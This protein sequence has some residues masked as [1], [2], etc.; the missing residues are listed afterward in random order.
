MPSTDVL[1]SI[2][3]LGVLCT[4]AAFLIFAALI[5]EI[6]PV[7]STVITY[8]NP[9]VATLLGVVVLDETFTIAMGLG[10][11]LVIA[12]SALATRQNRPAQ[13]E[14]AAVTPEAVPQV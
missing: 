7:R 10:F 12:G 13:V 4:A 5:A 8:I 6:G 2:A 9:A 1:I 14:P 3:V 11:A